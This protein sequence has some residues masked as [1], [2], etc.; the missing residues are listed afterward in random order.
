MKGISFSDV[1]Y[2][3]TKLR[4]EIGRRIGERARLKA[5][6]DWHAKREPRPCGMTIHTAIGCPLRCIYCYIAD[7]GFDF[8]SIRPYGLTHLEL[9]YALLY[10]PYF[11]PGLFGTYAA[12]G[13][14]SE[15]FHE[16][17]KDKTIEYIE[18]ILRHLGNPV[19]FSSKAHIDES[20]SKRLAS[21]RGPLS[22]LITIIT[23]KLAKILEPLAPP[24]LI[25]FE[26]LK[27]LSKA[28]LKPALFYRPIIPG[29]NDSDEAEEVFKEARRAG[30]FAVVLGGLRVTPR[31]LEGLKRV[32]VDV[33]P[34]LSRVEGEVRPNK[35]TPVD[36][37][38]I[39]EELARLAKDKGLVPLKAACCATTLTIYLSKGVKVPCFGLCYTKEGLCTSCPAKCW[40]S[41]PPIEVGDVKEVF[42]KYL[43]VNPVD[44]I[45]EGYVLKVKLSS[46]R[47]RNRALKK[48]GHLKLVETLYRRKVE[49]TA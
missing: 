14:V 38:D 36:V 49:V 34:I 31:I 39:K 27:N 9:I 18:A 33:N 23:L 6:R 15:P 32:G 42:R 44:V 26:S 24:P 25:R 43:K 30:A 5:E 47:E 22:P 40:E 3:K 13:S 7:M 20:T 37:S 46:R 16:L 29:V 48:R 11:V 4:Y 8:S 10:N 12:V 1:E 28:G 21:S 2:R 19:Q 41:L 45:E 17:V 35:Q